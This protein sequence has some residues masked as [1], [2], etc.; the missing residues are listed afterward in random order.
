MCW[1]GDVWEG[2]VWQIVELLAIFLL[3]WENAM[4]KTAHR[5]VYWAYT[6]RDNGASWESCRRQ[7]QEAEGSHFEPQ[8]L[9]RENELEMV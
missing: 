1:E 7:G 2:D 6:Q 5:G 9:I 8:A 3:L 4:T